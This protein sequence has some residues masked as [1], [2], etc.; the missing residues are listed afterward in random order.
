MINKTRDGVVYFVIFF[1]IGIFQDCIAAAQIDSEKSNITIGFSLGTRREERWLR[2]QKLFTEKVKELGGAVNIKFANNDSILQMSQAE[3]LIMQGVDI[4]VIVPHDGE[5]AADIVAMAHNEGIKVIAYDRLIKNCDLDFYVSFDNVMVGELQAK[6]ILSVIDRGDFAYIGGSQND[7]NSYLV[8][9]GTF[10]IIQ[11][12]I[13]NGHIN[14]VL[15]TFTEDWRPDIAFDHLKAYLEKNKHIDA[16]ICANDGTAF[17]A[18]QALKEYELAG[19]VPVSGQDAELPACQ[20][21]VQGLQTVT[22]YK[23][24][25]LLAEKAAQIAMLIAQRK[26]VE[27]NKTIY[28]GAIEVPSYLID[29]IAVTKENMDDTIIKD[30]FHSREDVYIKN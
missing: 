28:N 26:A 5:T 10:N 13:N 21:I 24:I 16:V 7:H 4:L 25:R 3:N 2:D 19:K 9:N 1:L 12:I 22:V 29:P 20:R 15:D 11:P 17:G 18:I 30:G 6:S 23:P 27:P 8:K 14:L